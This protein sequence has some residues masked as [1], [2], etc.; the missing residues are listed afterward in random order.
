VEVL[1]LEKLK[2]R[3]VRNEEIR[4]GIRTGEIDETPVER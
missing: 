3:D 1:Y 4:L 2:A